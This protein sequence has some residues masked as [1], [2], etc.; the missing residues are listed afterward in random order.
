M[1]SNKLENSTL[2]IK[3]VVLLK[4]MWLDINQQDQ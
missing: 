1:E 3:L 2:P 4:H